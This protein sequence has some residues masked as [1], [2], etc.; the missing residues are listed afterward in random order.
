MHVDCNSDQHDKLFLMVAVANNCLI[1]LEAQ[2]TGGNPSLVL[3]T[4]LPKAGEVVDLRRELTT[5][6]L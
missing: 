1:E 6:T 3:E 2:S 5:A 4:Q